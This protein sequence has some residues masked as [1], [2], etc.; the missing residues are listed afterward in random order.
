MHR[1]ASIRWKLL[2]LA[3]SPALVAVV[4]VGAVLAVTQGERQQDALRRRAGA[5]AALAAEQ[6]RSAVAFEDQQT[7]REVFS[8]IAQ[9]ED[10]LSIAVYR[11]NGTLLYGQGAPLPYATVRKLGGVLARDNDFVAVAPVGFRLKVPAARSRSRSR[12]RSSSRI[13]HASFRSR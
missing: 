13:V 10:V 9:D 1:L 11:E 12:R 7:A 6:V 3:A 2:L 8:S 4:V 5:Y